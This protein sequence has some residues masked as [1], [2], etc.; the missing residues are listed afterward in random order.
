M[1]GLPGK[2]SPSIKP[3][4]KATK[5]PAP[6]AAQIKKAE[7]AFRKLVKSGK[8]KDIKA[9]RDKIKQQYGVRPN[10]MTN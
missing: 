2:V 9:A 5:S 10:G 8:V 4:P 6:S 1:I 7:D 3:K